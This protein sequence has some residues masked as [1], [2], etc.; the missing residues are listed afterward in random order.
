MRKVILS[1]ILIG[2]FY[3]CTTDSATTTTKEVEKTEV[4]IKKSEKKFYKK[5]ENTPLTG[6]DKLVKAASNDK[7]VV[8]WEGS[9]PTGTHMGNLELVG[10][11]IVFKND[12]LKSVELTFDM[13]SIS[14]SDITNPDYN[15]KLINHLRSNDFFNV[16]NYPQAILKSTEITNKVDYYSV[17]ADLTIKGITQT[18]VVPVYIKENEETKLLVG[19]VEIDRTKFNIHYKSKSIFP[20]LGDKFISDNFTV[21]FAI[22]QKK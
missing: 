4:A 9:K 17:K 18:V 15:A 2:A 14:C 7:G 5:P 16:E 10:K 12:E 13:N 1:L 8:Q 11:E 20:N 3:A 6:L 21:K 19:G 22:P